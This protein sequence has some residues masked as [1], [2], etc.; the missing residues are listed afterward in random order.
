MLGF[1]GLKSVTVIEAD[2]QAFG[3]DVAE[4][5]VDDAV[6][7]LSALTE[8]CNAQLGISA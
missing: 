4:Q 2:K 1:I 7:K 6:R 5:S 8:S 3:P